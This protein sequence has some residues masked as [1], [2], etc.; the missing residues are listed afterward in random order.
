[1][2]LGLKLRRE[3]LMESLAPAREL[4]PRPFTAAHELAAAT[5]AKDAIGFDHYF[6]VVGMT[7]SR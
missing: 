2:D 4:P 7:D 5:V 1:M 6:C 3:G